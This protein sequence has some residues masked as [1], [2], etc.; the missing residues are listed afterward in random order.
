MSIRA[1]FRFR[2][3]RWWKLTCVV[4]AVTMSLTAAALPNATWPVIA[5]APFAFPI[6]SLPFVVILLLLLPRDRRSSGVAERVAPA[7]RRA[8]QHAIDA[9]R[10]RASARAVDQALE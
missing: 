1:Y 6:A 5:M 9:A 2:L 3:L 10:P 4:C 8:K 7:E